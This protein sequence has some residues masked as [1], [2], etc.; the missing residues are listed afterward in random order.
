MAL[1]KARVFSGDSYPG[2]SY[3]MELR[4]SPSS[5]AVSVHTGVAH[6]TPGAAREQLEN[7]LA[8]CFRSGDVVRIEGTVF[9]NLP[10]AIAEARRLWP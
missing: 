10:G 5:A 4:V 2:P 9:N 7:E 8:V 3:F 6:K 1:I